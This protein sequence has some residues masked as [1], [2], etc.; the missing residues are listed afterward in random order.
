V[1]PGSIEVSESAI[2]YGY[3]RHQVLRG[4]RPD[5]VS[6]NQCFLIKNVSLMRLTYQIRLL[7]FLA[8]E[9]GIRLVLRIPKSCQL[10]P[11]LL[12]FVKDHS[13]AVTVERAK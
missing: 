3:T 10:S 4:A 13:A 11:D 6:G 1:R 9:R 2:E 8:T 7:T 5:A 12:G